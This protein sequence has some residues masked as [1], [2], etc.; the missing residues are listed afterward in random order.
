MSFSK[1]SNQSLQRLLS[2]KI[3]K[4]FTFGNGLEISDSETIPQEIMLPEISNSE[5]SLSILPS[6]PTTDIIQRQQI[7]GEYEVLSNC[8]AF[9]KV[10]LESYE[11]G[12]STFNS[13]SASTL[14]GANG[15]TRIISKDITLDEAK[16]LFIRNNFN[17]LKK[18]RI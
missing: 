5:I 3:Q 16:L 10:F 17:F 13:V 2:V 9:G 15:Y 7:N 12:G 8:Y 6:D 14:K 11:D 18:S 1:I 4:I